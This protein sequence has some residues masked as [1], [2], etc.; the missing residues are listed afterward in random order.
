MRRETL[1]SFFANLPS[2]AA[3]RRFD[4]ARVHIPAFPEKRANGRDREKA[5]YQENYK[6]YKCSNKHTHTPR[7]QL[8]NRY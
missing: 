1:R 4:R 3:A 7:E 6:Q 2:R 5:H 8:C